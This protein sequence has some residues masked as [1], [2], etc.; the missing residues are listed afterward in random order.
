MSLPW[1]ER[2]PMLSVNPDAAKRG[3]LARLA[4]ELMDA[5]ARI[6]GLEVEIGVLR[7]IMELERRAT[8]DALAQEKPR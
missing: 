2:V 7:N 8:R 3:D 6:A 1:D 5:N 4:S